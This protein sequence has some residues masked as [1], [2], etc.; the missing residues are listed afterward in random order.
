MGIPAGP[1]LK[2][3]SLHSV[4]NVM[5]IRPS[6]VEIG[7]H[8]VALPGIASAEPL[9]RGCNQRDW[10]E[11]LTALGIRHLV[12]PL[13][14][15]VEDACV[16]AR[17]HPASSESETNKSGVLYDLAHKDEG[18][19]ARLHFLFEAAEQIG[20]LIGLSM[21]N[22]QASRMSGPFQSH[23]NEQGVSFDDLLK[24]AT[25]TES[26]LMRSVEKKNATQ[27]RRRAMQRDKMQAALNSAVDWMGAAVRG[28]Q[29][30]WVEVCRGGGTDPDLP[31][32]PSHVNPLAHLEPILT[33]RLIKSLAK[34]GEDAAKAKLGPWVAGSNDF[35][36]NGS[37]DLHIAPFTVQHDVPLGQRA[38]PGPTATADNEA[39]R[40]PQICWLASG[41]GESAARGPQRAALWRSVMRGCWPLVSITLSEETDHRGWKDMAQIATFNRQ[42]VGG[43]YLR[44]CP[45]ILAH[46]PE[47]VA[48]G[49]I[50]AATD[51][52]G[53]YYAFLTE[54]LRGGLKLS[55]LPGSY[56][57]YWFDPASGRGLDYGD[58]IEGG[59]RCAV[60]TPGSV[61]HA[62]LI[63][64]Q[65]ELPDP[66][67]VW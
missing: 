8:R 66:F 60:P 42:W 36:W 20:V 2:K 53:R 5:A 38:I 51:G 16:F 41:R 63:L 54:S 22:A 7:G 57:Y 65:E 45:E 9:M 56:R 43:G 32:A 47:R 34:P 62:L 37:G 17:R 35:A 40:R 18:V 52:A 44:P 33:Q 24:G 39:P 26:A 21:F 30:V 46:T 10:L 13:N 1:R 15:G 64:E 67:S 29:G 19:F 4:A 59:L 48:D 25:A 12:I 23:C 6:R 31:P 50:C 28:R 49:K 58:G 61:R 55:T 3:F 11:K 14:N 27:I